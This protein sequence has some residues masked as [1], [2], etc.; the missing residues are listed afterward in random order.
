[1][2]HRK[3]VLTG[4]WVWVEQL[5]QDVRYALR[6]HRAQPNLRPGRDPD[7]R[8]RHRHEHG[9]LQRVQ[10]G[11]PASAR[12][13]QRRQ[14]GV[15]LHNR[16]RLRTGSRHG[17]GLRRLARSGR[18]RSMRMVAYRN[19]DYTLVSPQG[20]ARVRA[21]MV[22]EDFWD[23]SGA[24]PAA[25]R[26]PL[27]EE[28]GAVLLS[29][30]FAQR[31]F[32]GDPD[33]IGR[34]VT[35]DG[36]QVAIVGILPEHFRFE[37]PGSAWP[38]FRPRDVDVYQPMIVSSERGGGPVQLLSVVGRLEV[39]ATLEGRARGDRSDPR[40]VR[41]GVSRIPSTISECCAPSPCMTS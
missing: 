34:T 25:G 18:R 1:M 17:S 19:A 2:P 23:L 7:T 40:R 8:G 20:A 22:T 15:A 21:A 16:Q 27:P 26:L 24:K 6:S 39:G 35:L 10:R 14:A 37:L 3:R 31:W 29:S 33:V 13:P 41:T 32:A 4:A 38:G 5:I 30:S 36:R 11:R 28:R 12:V 9:D